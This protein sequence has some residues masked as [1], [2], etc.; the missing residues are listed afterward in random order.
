M[1]GRDDILI[2]IL[3]TKK[4]SSKFE[5]MSSNTNHPTGLTTVVNKLQV[6]RL[7]GLSNIQIQVNKLAQIRISNSNQCLSFSKI[8][9][10]LG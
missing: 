6:K 7:K 2:F 3:D 8:G 5:T 10:L 1:V 4:M 9:I